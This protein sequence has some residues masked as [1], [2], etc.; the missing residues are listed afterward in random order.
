MS[1]EVQIAIY[2][3][4]SEAEIAK[5]LLTA[6]GVPCML[7]HDDAGSTYP[8]LHQSLGIRLVVPENF[9]DEAKALLD[10]A[11]ADAR[12]GNPK[13]TRLELPEL[14]TAVSLVTR[15]VPVLARLRRAVV[16]ALF[17]IAA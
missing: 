13:T 2:T 6:N 10:E 9:A 14:T 1:G 12:S 16:H 8:Q 4:I 7:A 17:C 3:D 15:R 11:Q 5:G